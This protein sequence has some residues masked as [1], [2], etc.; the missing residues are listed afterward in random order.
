MKEHLAFVL[1]L[2]FYTIR[3]QEAT[4]TRP[5]LQRQRLLTL[6]AGVSFK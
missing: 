4:P 5:A 3:P 2:R 6:S 1:D